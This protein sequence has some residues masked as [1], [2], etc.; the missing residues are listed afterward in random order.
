MVPL[1]INLSIP[2]S[3]QSLPRSPSWTKD[4]PH[5]QKGKIWSPSIPGG[6]VHALFSCLL[7]TDRLHT[8]QLS[9]PYRKG[10]QQP[11]PKILGFKSCFRF[12]SVTRSCSA[13]TLG[14]LHIPQELPKDTEHPYWL[15]FGFILPWKNNSLPSELL[16]EGFVYITPWGKSQQSK[17]IFH[18]P[19]WKYPLGG[20]GES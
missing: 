15:F 6:E 4:S 11:R 3:N 10:L 13:G 2:N 16:V 5:P 18:S 19:F 17:T 1:H 9:Y 8:S 20:W 7:R 14:L 12:I